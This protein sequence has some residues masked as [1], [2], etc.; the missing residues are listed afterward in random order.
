MTMAPTAR[1][2]AAVDFSEPSR[3]ALTFAARLAVQCGS[4][5]HVVYA[6]EPI[7]AVAARARGIDLTS[8]SRDALR[9]FTASTW[10]AGEQDARFHVIE[11]EPAHA[12]QNLAHR[13]SVE[14]VVLGAHGMS[15]PSRLVF[16]STV[17]RLLRRADLSIVVVPDTWEPPMPDR[18][19]LAGIGPIF[20]GVDLT[21]PSIEAATAGARL[22]TLLKAEAVLIHVVP[23]LRVP[24][25]WKRDADEATR[26][27][28]ALAQREVEAMT[29]HLCTPDC[30][31]LEVTSG[32][33]PQSLA[34]A[35]RASPHSMLVLGRALQNGIAPPGS[36]AYRALT[37]VSVPVMMH[38]ARH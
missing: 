31:R 3:K 2:L 17:E 25:R 13:E 15:G 27:Q 1:V 22:A 9:T 8:E 14:V 36:N 18:S 26:T 16:G 7:L 11:G 35:V 19:D 4:E 28:L 23:R 24:D 12:I 5:L 37:L 21:V 33:V 30:M 20:C 32:D 6:E 29:R 10:P 38:V 34:E